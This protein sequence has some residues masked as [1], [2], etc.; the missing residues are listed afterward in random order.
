MTLMTITSPRTDSKSDTQP[1]GEEASSR[2]ISARRGATE[3]VERLSN[4]SLKRVVEPDEAVP[5]QVGEGQLLPDELMSV[6][7]LGLDLTAEQKA[8]LSREEIA[9]IA[10]TGVRFESILM[11][12][13]SID[14]LNRD[15]D[16]P[17]VIYILHEIGEET[18]HSRLFLRMISQLKPRAQ[19]PFETKAARLLH[20]LAV[21]L[22]AA[23][24]AMFCVAVL[25]GEEIPDL[26]QKLAGEHPGTDPFIRAVNRYH[27]QEEARHL[28]FA[29]V[30]LPELWESASPIDRFMVRHVSPLMAAG[31]FAGI[32]NPGV[33]RVIGLPG[34]KTWRAANHTPQRIDLKH[35]ALR[36][37]LGALM[38]ARAFVPGKIPVIWRKVCGV[39]KSGNPA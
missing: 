24:P 7:G 31:M 22:L 17:R 36:P 10:G 39:D 29:R 28:A 33:Y 26:L 13:F 3:R 15:F 11:G 34:W 12:G 6:A 38:E 14:I 4:L 8:L 32:V 1:E 23:M 27:R 20:S 2:S 25:T 21:P 35:R 30:V 16:D 37:I 9:S 19:N 18:R 5:G